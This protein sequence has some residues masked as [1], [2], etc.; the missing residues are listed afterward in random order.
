[1]S[2]P[3]VALSANATADD[4]RNY[5]AVGMNAHVPKPFK[6]EMLFEVVKNVLNQEEPSHVA[7]EE[8]LEINVSYSTSE[9]DAI[10]GGDDQF[11]LSVLQTF[12]STIP[13][14]LNN[15]ESAVKSRDAQAVRSIAHQLKPSIDLLHIHSAKELVRT[16]EKEASNGTPDFSRIHQLVLTF[17]K[18]LNSVLLEIQK[19]LDQ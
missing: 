18:L 7:H 9:L 10:G 16:I 1:M 5:L 14:Q 4:T 11:V 13:K 6:K 12:V 19:E 15:L 8:T 3:I 2:I 17:T